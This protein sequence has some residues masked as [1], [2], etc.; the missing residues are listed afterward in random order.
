VTD[1]RP[2]GAALAKILRN[3]AAAVEALDEAQ[4]EKFAA[5]LRRKDLS[6]GDDIDTKRAEKNRHA[7]IDTVELQLVLNRLNEFATRDEG[8]RLLDKL[9]LS[10][11]ELERIARL[12]NIHF[13]K[14]DNVPRIKEKLVE[15]II[16]SR[17]SSRAIRG[18]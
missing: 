7:K 3:I 17:L 2:R 10:R 18:Q 12:R 14:D 4:L 1:Q 11:K 6:V 15:A 16:G 5:N 9:D 13:T 8:A